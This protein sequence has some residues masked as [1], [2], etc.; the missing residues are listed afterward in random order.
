MKK[1][2]SKILGVGLTLALLTS[3]L[4]TAAPVSAISAPTVTLSTGVIS[5]PA[6]YTI[7]FQVVKA[8]AVG[9]QIVV[10]LPTGTDASALAVANDVQIGAGPGIGAAGYAL[11]NSVGGYTAPAVPPAA[12]TLTIS[13]GAGEAINAAAWVQLVIGTTNGVKNPAAIASYNLTV[14]TQTPGPPIV[15]VEAAAT[16][17]AYST[18]APVIPATPG[19]VRWYNTAGVQMGIDSTATPIGVALADIVAKAGVGW[20]IE[21]GPGTY[22]EAVPIATNSVTIK[23]TG[24]AAETIVVGNFTITGTSVTVSGFTIT[25]N[26]AM[27]TGAN[28]DKATFENCI[29]TKTGTGAT[30][31]TLLTYGNTTAL[32]TGTINLCTFDTSLGTVVDNAILVAAGGLGL[33]VSNCTFVVDGAV[34]AEDS[35]IN[36]AATAGTT[37]ISGNTISGAS[38]I[39]VTVTG[40]GTTAVTSNT[41]S[42]LNSA[43]NIAAGTVTISSNTID[44]CGLL[45]TTTLLTGQAAIDVVATIGNLTSLSIT[46][47]TIT[48]CPN[49]I[50]EVDTD[51]NLVNMMFNNLTGNTLG[52]DN[53]D[54]V[55]NILNATH[56][57][58]GAATGPAAGMNVATTGGGQIDATG[59]LG[60]EA[61]GT[62]NTGLAALVAKTTV[63]VDVTATLA[64][65]GAN[66]AIIGVGN[67]AAN[68]QSATELP[69]LAGGFYDVYVT[70]AT[71]GD[72]A[73]VLIKFYN[74]NITANTTIFAWGTLAGGWQSCTANA[75]GVNLFG[76]YAY[77]TVTGAT[78][79]DIAGLAGMPFALCE[80]PL[81]ALGTPVISTP[82]VGAKDVSLR[83]V[84]GWAPVAGADA[85][86]FQLAD[87][88][89][90]VLPIMDS[91]GDLGRLVVT[92]YA[93]VA[94]LDYS[95]S[96][97]WRV[98]AVSGTVEAGN[99]AEG[100]WGGGVFSTVAEVI[101]EPEPEPEA[102]IWT[103]PQCGL[104]FDTRA[105]LAAHV[106]S[107]HPPEEPPVITIEQP[108]IVVPLPAET[109]ITPAWI[110]A[111]I[112]VGAVLVI[113]VIVLI[114]RTRRVA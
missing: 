9:D 50:I 12:Q 72:L 20:T 78:T 94:G 8:L 103:C 82:A 17:V 104:T 87:N 7:T 112:G 76:G 2:L 75:Q 79:P 55:A 74:A 91:S 19:T 43:L 27:G 44:A 48:N 54:A 86:Y 34:T 11:Q 113:A 65:G 110:Y 58:W 31:E 101:P 56:N 13:L 93:Y 106:A 73:S 21:V 22:A 57:W 36:T 29:F 35:A 4:L 15:A 89:N 98:K 26:A 83:P 71:A 53:D 63:G 80:A 3:L 88:P 18:T 107:A 59:Y 105:A 45:A 70:E 68:P 77:V 16:S 32:G 23:P 102:P 66:P 95:K 69:A 90:F 114:V 85:Y 111:I 92:Y 99:L 47:N 14:A 52:V 10:T 61:T 1:K 64:A 25:G 84:F 100:S 51:S 49:D 109:P 62:F 41:F 24:T 40:A 60:G 33:T 5:T 6:V 28:G 37:T 97:Y 39:G 38:G 96:Y 42:N 67:Y 81:T 46:N 108:D 30:P